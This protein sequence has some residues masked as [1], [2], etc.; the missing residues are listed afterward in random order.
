MPVRLRHKIEKK[1]VAK[2]KKE[3]RHAKK[4]P[5][6]HP[7]KKPEK[8]NIPNSFPYKD[9]LLAEIEQERTRKEEERLRRIEE[10]R[11]KKQGVNGAAKGEM[12]VENEEKMGGLSD[13]EEGSG[14]EGDE[15]EDGAP[16]VSP[17]RSMS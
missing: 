13:E 6:L 7:K 3:R 16:V 2:A 4:H 1:V 12:E 8:L 17:R 15:M 10:A 11:A 5:E 9:Q 14:N